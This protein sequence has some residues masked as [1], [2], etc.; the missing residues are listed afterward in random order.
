MKLIDEKIKTNFPDE[1]VYKIPERYSI[2]S[3]Q[4]LPSFIKD[5]L[6]KKF[7][8]DC[9]E[10]DKDSLLDFFKS[11]IPSKDSNIKARLIEGEEVKILA[12]MIIESDIKKGI[13]KFAIPDLSIKMEEG[14][15]SSYIIKK[16]PQLR[17]GEVWGVVTLGYTPPEGKEK[18]FVEILDFRPF[19]PYEVNLEYFINVRKEFTIYEWIDVLIRSMEYNPDGFDNINQKLIFLTRLLVFIEPNLNLIELAPKGTGKSY[20][21]GNL[22]KYGW[23]ISGGTISR[24]KLF[25]DIARQSPGIITMYDFVAMD[26]IQTINFSDENELRGALKSYLESGEFAVAKT[27]QTSSS[28]LILLGNI[29]LNHEMKPIN[30]KYFIELPSF[31]QE[32]ALL[33]RFH[34]FIEGWKLPRIKEDLKING[35]TLNVEYFSEILTSLRTVSNYSAIVSEVLD[36]P[37]KADTRDTKAVKRLCTAYFKLLFPHIKK[38]EEV[39]KE[40]FENFCFRP[41]LQ[42][43]EI[44]RKQIFLIDNEFSPDMPDI[45]IR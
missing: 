37:E 43:R 18:G 38:A 39:N 17:E 9:G 41:A 29:S 15:I 33:D 42:K 32:S 13:H 12:R 45:K 34:G 24:A 7:T 6:I 1:S 36:I 26:E 10:L 21:F 25:F 8:N 22:S 44:I 14:R 11:H 4:N 3:G 28:G 40:D 31:F 5:W 20:I 23:L 16:F 2:F 19:K 27:R 30:N 35:Y